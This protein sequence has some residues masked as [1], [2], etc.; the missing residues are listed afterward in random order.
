MNALVS[1]FYGEDNSVQDAT[2]VNIAHDD[3]CHATLR[4]PAIVLI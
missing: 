2:A 3:I 4:A 1:L